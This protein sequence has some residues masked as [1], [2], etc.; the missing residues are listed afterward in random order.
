MQEGKW[1]LDFSSLVLWGLDAVFML[2]GLLA[3][4]V[5]VVVP[6]QGGIPM[7][8]KVNGA[9]IPLVYRHAAG[10]L[11][12]IINLAL[13]W[14]IHLVLASAKRNNP[15]IKR[16]VYI[17]NSVGALVLLGGLLSLGLGYEYTTVDGHLTSFRITLDSPP[18]ELWGWLSNGVVWGMVILATAAVFDKGVEL[19]REELRLREEQALT[20]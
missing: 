3:L 4:L 11:F 10:Y 5:L 1:R 19:R 2:G 14:S 18:T 6:F 16:N 13:L 17:L 20:I 8:F 15:F 9:D 12:L 7:D